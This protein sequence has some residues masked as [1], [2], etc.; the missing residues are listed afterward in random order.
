MLIDEGGYLDTFLT[1]TT[2]LLDSGAALAGKVYDYKSQANALA[3]QAAQSDAAVHISKINAQASVARA[4]AEAAKS[5]FDFSGAGE[6]LVATV[7]D[8]KNIILIGAAGLLAVALIL[9][10]R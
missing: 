8:N 2:K 4:E 1:G 9:K 3:A 5:R 7:G 6:R 10:A